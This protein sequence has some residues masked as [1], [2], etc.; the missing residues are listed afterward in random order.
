MKKYAG[1]IK[2]RSLIG[3]GL[4]VFAIL[5]FLDNIGI[6]F[7][8]TVLHNWPIAVVI[9]GVAL[10]LGPHKTAPTSDSNR[11]LPYFLIGFGLLFF[12]ARLFHFSMGALIVPLVLLFVGFHVLGLDRHSYKNRSKK[13]PVTQLELKEG[14]EEKIFDKETVFE[15]ET[16]IDVF[17]ILGGG[18]YSTRSHNL[19][20]GNI[21]ALLG[22]AKVDI[23]DA[24]T[25][26]DV[27]EIDI[28]AFMGGAELL[29]PP[30]W[31]VTVKVLPI[32]GG[33]SNKT[34]CL[35]DKMQVR[36]KHLIV[37]GI[38][39]LGGVEIRN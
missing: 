39:L 5:L 32:L 35:A 19:A 21:I 6:R 38:A 31:Q 22:G 18:D 25:H 28:L 26:K 15:G 3:L 4:I 33:V 12:I 2:P 27:I 11:L 13:E 10:L 23:R 30:H 14:E 9:I 1:Y 16:K 34:T 36:K 24:D 7:L 29:V 17:T 20:G 8:H 37:T